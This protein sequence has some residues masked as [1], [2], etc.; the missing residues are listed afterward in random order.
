MQANTTIHR[1]DVVRYQ[2]ACG[3]VVEA[4]TKAINA[5]GSLTVQAI[6]PLRDDGTPVPAFMGFVYRIDA[7][8]L[9][10]CAR[11]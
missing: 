8:D 1:G 4:I 3:A 11:A 5:D 2:S 7:R 6:R 9:R 10:A